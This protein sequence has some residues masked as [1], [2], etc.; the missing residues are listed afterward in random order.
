V[1]GIYYVPNWLFFAFSCAATRLFSLA[2]LFFQTLSGQL[3]NEAT[4]TAAIYNDL[5]TYPPAAGLLYQQELKAYVKSV[6]EQNWPAHHRSQV[7][8]ESS[9]VLRTFKNDFFAFVPP[10]TRPPLAAAG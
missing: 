5:A 2:G 3:D 9:T 1:A 4:I 8:Q 7:P 10:D 6:I